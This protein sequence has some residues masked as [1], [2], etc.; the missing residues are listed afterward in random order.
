M[1]GDS[2]LFISLFLLLV[3]AWLIRRFPR[4]LHCWLLREFESASF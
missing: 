2:R 3:G 1:I 4:G